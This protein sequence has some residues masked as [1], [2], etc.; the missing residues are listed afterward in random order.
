MRLEDMLKDISG[1]TNQVIKT[2]CFEGQNTLLES[3][4]LIQTKMNEVIQAIN[5]G[6]IKG[7]K[8]DTPNVQV[9]NTETLEPGNNA[10]VTQTG[11]ILNPILNF[12]IPKGEKGDKGDTGKASESIQDDVI[13]LDTTWSSTKVDSLFK[14]I[15]DTQGLEYITENNFYPIN[16]SK[17]GVITDIKLDG[18]TLVVDDNN[19][20]VIPGTQGA[21]IKSVGDGVAEIK[22]NSVNGSKNLININDLDFKI[23]KYINAQGSLVSSDE[24]SVSG[25]IKFVKNQQYIVPSGMYSSSIG[26]TLYDKNKNFLKTLPLSSPKGSSN[27]FSVSEGEYIR[28]NLYKNTGYRMYYGNVLKN[29]L[30]YV[31]N[32][33][34]VLY[35]DTDGTWKKPTLRQWDS[36]EKHSDGKYYY[37]K[38]SDVYTFNGTESWGV[39]GTDPSSGTNEL[40]FYLRKITNGKNNGDCVSDKFTRQGSPYFFKG[41]CFVAVQTDGQTYVRIAK[42]KLSTQDV[43]GFKTWLQNNNLNTVY[44]L[45][46]EQVFECTPIDLISYD[47]QTNYSIECGPIYPKSTLYINSDYGNVLSN[48]VRRMTQIEEDRIE[49]RKALIRGDFRLLAEKTYPDDFIKKEELPNE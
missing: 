32:N 24:F 17:N 27:V 38:R 21:M 28:I 20:V 39:T 8:G 46:Q 30:R 31:E 34:K 9:G 41:E 44:E 26:I 7:D 2:N 40:L 15:V 49:D 19:N 48:I 6:I 12:A 47:A 23:D 14:N 33:K 29:D 18:K 11:D 13:S 37:H 1:M 43:Q 45:A 5:D 42:S 22:L 36:I 25:Y 3:I 10:S 4:L 35:K 16:S